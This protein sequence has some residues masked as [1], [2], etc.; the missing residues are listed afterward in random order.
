MVLQVL[1]IFYTCANANLVNL[2]VQGMRKHI[3][4]APQP[5]IKMQL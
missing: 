2:L 1:A 4:L 5:H 3:C